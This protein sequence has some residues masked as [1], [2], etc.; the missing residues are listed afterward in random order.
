MGLICVL[1]TGTRRPLQKSF[2]ESV[3]S[4]RRYEFPAI[5]LVASGRLG[6]N[7]KA[8][9]SGRGPASLATWPAALNGGRER[10]FSSHG[11]AGLASRSIPTS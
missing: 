5:S 7:S 1:Y 10:N 2:A 9:L 4:L 8:A 11:I 6:G 3:L